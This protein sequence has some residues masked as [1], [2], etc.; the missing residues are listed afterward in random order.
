M[1]KLA[2]ILATGIIFI[3]AN[4]I[5]AQNAFVNQQLT[6]H[7][8]L[9][10]PDGK[11]SENPEVRQKIY[12]KDSYVVLEVNK[13][14]NTTAVDFIGTVVAT[15][16]DKIIETVIYT[17]PQMKSMYLLSFKFSYKIEGKYLFLEGIENPFNEIWIKISD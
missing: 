11:V 8:E 5:K 7:W 15:G 17:N 4:S 9:C 6:G 14:D 13:I 10:T 1:K 12:T 2:F 3:A 16:E